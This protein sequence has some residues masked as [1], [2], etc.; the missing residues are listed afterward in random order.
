MQKLFSN[1]LLPVTL[2]RHAAKTVGNAIELANRLECN[3]HILYLPL[4][5]FF[6]S[7]NHSSRKKKLAIIQQQLMLRIRKGLLLQ[8]IYA[9]GNPFAEIRNYILSHDIDI[10]CIPDRF[11]PLWYPSS[12]LYPFSTSRES[13]FAVIRSSSTK[14]FTGCDKILLP[15]GNAIP[16]RSI[17]AAVYIAR[18]FNASVHLLTKSNQT[19]ENIQVLQRTYQLLKENTQL[20]VICDTVEGNNFERSVIQYA[21]SVNAGLIVASMPDP[22]SDGIF[23]RIFPREGSFHSK[24]PLVLVE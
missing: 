11:R 15:V 9:G 18:Q 2:N 14:D 3:L 17:R 13:N 22:A 8:A 7:W 21:Q 24:V 16:V 5:P 23:Q 19:G 6:Q 1:I 12:P 20:D 4:T 10:L